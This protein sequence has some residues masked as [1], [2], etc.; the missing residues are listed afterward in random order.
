[1]TRGPVH[2]KNKELCVPLRPRISFLPRLALFRNPMGIFFTANF[3]ISSKVHRNCIT[4]DTTDT[5]RGCAEMA[6]MD[7]DMDVELEVE[8]ATVPRSLHPPPMP[9]HGIECLPGM[10]VPECLG[11][12]RVLSDR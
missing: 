7:V 5:T 11:D 4:Q 2:I 1:M 3:V 6:E 9:L 8:A 10:E 12:N